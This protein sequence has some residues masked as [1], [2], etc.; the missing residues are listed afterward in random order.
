MCTLAS[1]QQLEPNWTQI[2]LAAARRGDREAFASLVSPHTPKLQR[3]A[4]RLTRSAEDAEDVCQESLLKAFTKLDQFSA[5]KTEAHEFCAWLATI[6][7]NCALDFLRRKKASQ[8]VPLEECHEA[9]GTAAQAKSQW[10]EN[11]ET[12]YT[13]EQ[14]CKMIREAI[15]A[16]PPELQMVCLFRDMRELSTKEAAAH[17]GIS[18]IAVRL[19]LFRAHGQLRKMLSQRTRRQ[20]GQRRGLRAR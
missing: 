13:R 8:T 18:T 2:S 7:R 6:T 3:L 9:S 15:A 1:T 11:P 14:Q 10:G 17:L 16:L 20:M 12:G 5:N 19:R 4:H